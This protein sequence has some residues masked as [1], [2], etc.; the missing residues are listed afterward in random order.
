VSYQ[1]GEAELNRRVRWRDTLPE[2]PKM[3]AVWVM[4]DI[5]YGSFCG[6]EELEGRLSMSW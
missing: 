4:V 5:C 6:K 2:P 1:G 3:R